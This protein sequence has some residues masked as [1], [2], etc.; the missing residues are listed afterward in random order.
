MARTYDKSAMED[1]SLFSTATEF[2]ELELFSSLSFSGESEVLPN[3]TL[4][5]G[6]SLLDADWMTEK[7]EFNSTEPVLTDEVVATSSTGSA[8]L[9]TISP[10]EVS[11]ANN[12][13]EVT[14]M[15]ELEPQSEGNIFAGVEEI[16]KRLCAD[17]KIPYNDGNTSGPSSPSP[18]SVTSQGSDLCGNNADLHP[19]ESDDESVLSLSS[20]DIQTTP[21][22]SNVQVVKSPSRATLFT[23]YTKEKPAKVRSPQQKKRKREQNKDAATWYRIKKRDE[24]NSIQ[25]ELSGLEKENVDLKEKVTSLSKE[26]E[27]LKNLMLEVCK[28]KL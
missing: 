15:E 27:Y 12:A 21:V 28:T 8:L 11:A 24:Q 26:I 14:I 25:K 6:S 16:L 1:I 9:L 10:N 20:P 4:V 22:K 19:V 18:C 5:Y 7:L 17:R 2:E 13:P 23:P 3:K